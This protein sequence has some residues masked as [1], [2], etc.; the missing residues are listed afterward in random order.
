ENASNHGWAGQ[1]VWSLATITRARLALCENDHGAARRL[2]AKLHYQSLNPANGEGQ[3]AS[4]ASIASALAILDAEIALSEGNLA[5]AKLALDRARSDRT[6][7]DR[8]GSDRSACDRA[9]LLL[10]STKILLADGD[11]RAA[12]GQADACLTGVTL[13]TTL[14]DQVSALVLAAIAHRR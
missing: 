7:S 1:V 5:G 6:A 8:T 3:R 14:R 9:D 2:I 11:S 13:D 12:L 10:T 4:A